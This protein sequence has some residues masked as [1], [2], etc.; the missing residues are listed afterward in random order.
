GLGALV[1]IAVVETVE[2]AGLRVAAIVSLLGAGLL[3]AFGALL[4]G[5]QHRRRVDDAAATAR[6]IATCAAATGT[7]VA[8]LRLFAGALAALDQGVLVLDGELRVVSSNPR[9]AFLLDLPPVLLMPGA[10][11]A[12]IAHHAAVRGDLGPGDAA[13]LAA[14]A[15]ARTRGDARIDP[16]TVAGRTIEGRIAA[17]PGDGGFL[18]IYTEGS[19]A[20]RTAADIGA[21]QEA[22]ARQSAELADA[23]RLLETQGR[24]LQ[25]AQALTE[26]ADAGKSEFLATVSHEIRTPMNGILGMN[27][28]LLET[29]LSAEQRQFAEAI[30]N[31]AETLLSLVN[32]ILD[33]SKL[34][35]GRI[36]LETVDF[37]LASLVESAVVL[38]TPRA[39]IKKIE[40]GVYIHPVARRDLRGDPTR[41]RQVL[42]NLVGNAI[43]FTDRGSVEIDVRAHQLDDRRLKMRFAVTD[44]GIGIA[45][46][47]RA[48]LFG[49]FNQ[50]DASITRRYGGTGLG[51]AI[52]RQLVELMGGEIDV[53]SEPGRGSTFWFTL[54]LEVA[55]K[56]VL[57]E[58]TAVRSLAGLR[59]LVVDDTE[60][61]RRILRRQLESMGLNVAEA[62]DGIEALT[63]LESAYGRSAPFDLV[64]MDH[65]MP[66]LSGT[67]VVARIRASESLG[68]PKIVLASSMGSSGS[69]VIERDQCDVVLTKPVRLQTMVECLI[70]LFGDRSGPIV[71]DAEEDEA[72][73]KSRS[74]SG[75]AREPGTAPRVL[76]AEDNQIN[77][78]LIQAILERDGFTV[79]NVENGVEAVAAAR[80]KPYDAV[81][82]DVQMPVMNGVEATAKLRALGGH[83]A[84]LPIIALT[85]NAMHGAREYYLAAGMTEYVSKPINRAELVAVLRRLIA[86]P[87]PAGVETSAAAAAPAA[88]TANEEGVE[89]PDLDEGQL[90]A[91]QAVLRAKEFAGL[92]TSY[93]ETS[94]ARAERIRALAGTQDLA[95]L[96]REAHDLK[97]VA[98]NFGARR[99]HDL[100]AALEK[101]CRGRRKQDI[102][103]LIEELGPAAERAC[104]AIR[105]RF[106]R[107][108][109]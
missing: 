2:A 11:Y 47:G 83:F 54:P 36:D 18:L 14:D 7:A 73:E 28:L 101:A 35:S 70:R 27:A 90:S 48:R 106:L 62:S 49:K 51:L 69:E 85:A 103:R 40:L 55:S 98:G 57:D 72:D 46:E 42:L 20:H 86:P 78:R 29:S 32:D 37:N 96:A 82:M 9:L 13:T 45:P 24:D 67:A 94:E 5:R 50:A 33:I 23:R 59:V 44:T 41:L 34:E 68:E 77:L 10:D 64:F 63:A 4:A 39:H 95:A 102:E 104:L 88:A 53:E 89:A 87:S 52:C 30:G 6:G 108:A 31:S 19:D 1:A 56:P 75:L 99:V 58:R 107:A 100:A 43:K 16:H 66:G 71:R 80:M 8:K 79:D 22:L 17:L 76:V 60:M 21:I 65:M 25:A 91:V 84:R 105:S 74:L 81:L 3:G 38:L 26:R 61:N 12:A 15:I 109:S 92:V 93:V 97:G